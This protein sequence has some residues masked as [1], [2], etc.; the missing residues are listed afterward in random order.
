MLTPGAACALSLQ[1][2][3]I[4]RQPSSLGRRVEP[5][6]RLLG[7]DDLPTHDQSMGSIGVTM[8]R[9]KL[10]NGAIRRYFID[11][12]FPYASL[13]EI[14]LSKGA[15]PSEDKMTFPARVLD[16]SLS[17]YADP[18]SLPVTARPCRARYRF[19]IG[20]QGSCLAVAG[21]WR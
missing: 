15:D 16:A 4:Y 12:E 6:S 17:R 19:A 3:C 8:F 20:A 5:R 18:A 9:N 1:G 7:R 11:M 21:V 13:Y 10:V 2:C 14:G